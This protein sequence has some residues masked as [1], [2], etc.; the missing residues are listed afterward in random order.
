MDPP[1]ELHLLMDRQGENEVQDLIESQL[2]EIGHHQE[3]R[4]LLLPI[5]PVITT[6]EDLRRHLLALQQALR[7]QE[8]QEDLRK[9]NL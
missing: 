3:T 4:Q 1:G 6:L 7:P 8:P 2:I 5:Q 9:M